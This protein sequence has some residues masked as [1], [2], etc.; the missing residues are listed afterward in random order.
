LGAALSGL[1]IPWLLSLLS[2]SGLTLGD[3]MMI[4][5]LLW[6]APP[7]VVRG[8]RR[9]AAAVDGPARTLLSAAWMLGLLAWVVAVPASLAGNQAVTRSAHWVGVAATALLYCAAMLLVTQRL[10]WP[11]YE[12]R[13]RGATIALAICDGAAVLA[14]VAALATGATFQDGRVDVDGPWGLGVIAVAVLS[15]V[16]ILVV[17][18]IHSA[19]WAAMT[20]AP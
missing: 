3:G 15:I 11:E 20:E 2:Q 19:T 9:A 10:A 18:R 14:T 5:P 12:R 1:G 8:V 6:F 4:L 7:F 16:A 17:A 13:W